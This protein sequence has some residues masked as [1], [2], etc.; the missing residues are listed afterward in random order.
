MEIQTATPSIHYAIY[1]LT[2]SAE[3]PVGY[4]VNRV[5]WD[6]IAPWRPPSGCAAVADPKGDHLIGS[7][8]HN[9][10]EAE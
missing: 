3:H 5:M 9:A 4:V 2:A 7:I 8:Y 10:A 6:G 1:Q